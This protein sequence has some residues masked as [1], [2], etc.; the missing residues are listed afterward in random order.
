M[1]DKLIVFAASSSRFYLQWEVELEDGDID[2]GA[3]LCEDPKEGTGNPPTE[4]GNWEHWMACKV[5]REL[6]DIIIDSR[7]AVFESESAAKRALAKIKVAWKQDREMPEWAKTALENGWK[8][9]KG[10]KA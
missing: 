5:V 3:T 4:R 6:P 8:P 1:A 9:P 2:L 7:G 10:W